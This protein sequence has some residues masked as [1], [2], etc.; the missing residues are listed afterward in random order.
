MRHCGRNKKGFTLIEIVVVIAII[1]ILGAIAT[2]SGMA[3]IKNNEK[4]AAATSVKNYWKL[5]T[6]TF[7]QL[8]LG[9][10]NAKKATD[11][12]TFLAA[13][14]GTNELV[15]STA[16]CSA[17]KEGGIY[18]QYLQDSKNTNNRYQLIA[19]SY[20]YKGRIFYTTDGK[21]VYEMKKKT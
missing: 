9:Y 13:Q 3:I 11:L 18:V 4:K 16:E 20:N 7:N 21:N 1:G 17:L 12:K 2:M 5:S 6:Q 8:N 10:K 14:L 15:V 19:L